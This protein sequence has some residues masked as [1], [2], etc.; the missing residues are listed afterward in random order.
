MMD[1]VQQQEESKFIWYVRGKRHDG[2][3][4]FE[5]RMVIEAYSEM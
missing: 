5:G 1:Y 2:R 4:K 3:Y